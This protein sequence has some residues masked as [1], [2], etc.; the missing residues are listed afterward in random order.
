MSW[1]TAALGELVVAEDVAAA[2]ADLAEGILGPLRDG[3]GLALSGGG[4][5]R[6]CYEE[7]ERRAERG[8][9][10]W[11]GATLVWGDERCVPP[12]D[13]ASNFRLASEAMPSVLARARSVLPMVTQRDP[14]QACTPSDAAEYAAVLRSISPLCLAHLGVGP[15]GHTASLFPQSPALQAEAGHLVVT[16]ADPRGNNPL[17][18]MT[19]TFEAIALFETVVLTVS[20]PAKAAALAAISQGED[21]PAARVRAARRVWVVDPEAAPWA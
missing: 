17:A 14:E 4:T 18:R 2:F 6:A 1:D 3:F 16:N 19:L 11:E 21:L 13:A 9:I 10:P 7:L 20:G 12:S 5:A 8:H 15:D